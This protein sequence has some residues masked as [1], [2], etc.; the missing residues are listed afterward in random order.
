MLIC[1]LY[2]GRVMK[3]HEMEDY[4]TLIELGIFI[5]PDFFWRGGGGGVG[6]GAPFVF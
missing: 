5:H 6:I 3:K 2:R 1:S 4:L